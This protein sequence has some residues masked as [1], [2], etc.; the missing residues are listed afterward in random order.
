MPCCMPSVADL[1]TK[2]KTPD[3]EVPFLSGCTRWEVFN[4]LWGIVENY[5]NKRETPLA[6]SL[7]L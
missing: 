2:K 5:Y 1:D 7:V 6:L 4:D 3:A